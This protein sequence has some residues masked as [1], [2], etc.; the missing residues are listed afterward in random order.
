MKN[1]EDPIVAETREIR[2]EMAARFG[3]DIDALCDFL[4]DEERKHQDRLVTRAPRPVQLVADVA[5][6]TK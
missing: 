3:N 6:R 2:R 1:Y 4:I 5:S